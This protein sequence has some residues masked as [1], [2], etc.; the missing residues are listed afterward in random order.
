MQIK[1]VW[2]ASNSVNST[3]G[4]LT[5]LCITFLFCRWVITSVVVGPTNFLCK[6]CL[7]HR[8]CSMRQIKITDLSKFSEGRDW[9]LTRKHVS[10]SYLLSCKP[11]LPDNLP[12]AHVQPNW[13]SILPI[14]MQ[15]TELLH[16]SDISS[17]S[18]LHPL[19]LLD[20]ML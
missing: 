9:I 18:H 17:Q 15:S 7:C 13:P 16:D 2:F 10:L 5:L 1:I 4:I 3:A 20:A 19:G 8:G 14:N 11:D 6:Q 12:H